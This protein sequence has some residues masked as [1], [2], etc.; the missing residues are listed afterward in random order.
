MDLGITRGFYGTSVTVSPQQFPALYLACRLLDSVYGSTGLPAYT[1][2]C[3]PGEA[4]TAD[5]ALAAMSE[6][7]LDAFLTTDT[8]HGRLTQGNLRRVIARH[9]LNA[10][11]EAQ[12]RVRLDV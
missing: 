5:A 10:F 7:D 9:V 4:A 2:Q 3:S 6:A 12:L 1:L 8:P 11:M